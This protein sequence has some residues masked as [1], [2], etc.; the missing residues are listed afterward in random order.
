MANR[1]RHSL[2]SIMALLLAVTMVI[3][4]LPLSVLA[5]DPVTQGLWTVYNDTASGYATYGDMGFTYYSPTT[6]MTYGANGGKDYVRSNNT[7]GSASNGIVV[8]ES[9]SYCDF[10]PVSDGTLT[11]YVGNASTKTGYVSKTDANGTSTA[12]GSYVPGGSDNYDTDGFKVTQGKTWATL[13][14]EVEKGYTYY[15]NLSGSKMFCYGAEFVAYTNVTGTISDSFGLGNYDIKFTNKTTGEVKNAAVTGN[16]YS[17]ILKPGYEY[18]ASLSGANALGYAISNDTR[19]VNVAVGDTQTANLTIEKSVSYLLSGNITGATSSLPADT[20]LVFVP[21]DT[22]SH[23]SVTA[24]VD[25]TKAT[26]TAQ[27]VAN[28]TYTATLEGACDY[29]LASAVTVI[30]DSSSAITRDIQLI[31]LPTYQVNG[32]FIGLTQTRGVYE[33]LSVQ[34]V[35]VTFTNVEDGYSYTGTPSAGTY[36]V[37]LRNGSYEASI[38]SEDYSTSTHVT[39]EGGATS[40]DLLLKKITVEPLTYRDTLYVGSDKEFKSVQAA[41]DEATAM[42]RTSGQRVTI[43]IDPGVYREQVVV[44]TPDITLESNGGTRD[45]T[46][47]TW[48]YG[49]GYK[50]YSCVD[51]CY[52]PY[53]D[54]DKFEKGNVTSYWGAAVITNKEAEGFRAK[55]ITFEN[56]FN[57]YMTDEEIADGAEPNGLEAISVARK[58]TT[59]VDSRE[60]TERAA[61]YVNYADKTEFLDCSFIGSQD[62]LYTCNVAYDAYYKNCYIE[63][64][65]DFIY[66]NGDVIFDGCEINLCGYDGTASAGYLTA[67]SSSEKY[68]AEFGY[69]FRGCYISYNDERD[70]TA[71]YLGRTWGDSARVTFIDTQLENSDMILGAGWSAMSGVNPTDPSV[72]LREFNTTYNGVQIDT[73]GRVTGAV[74]ELDRSQY[75]VENVMIANGWTPAYYTPS[76]ATAAVLASAPTMTSNGDLNAPNP[77]ETITLGYTPESDWADNDVSTIA[78]YAVAEGYDDTSLDT[79]LESATLLGVES[80]VSTNKFQIP[81]ECAGKYIMAVVTPVTIEG[82]AG[83]PSYIIDREKPVSATWSD[84]DNEGSIAPGSGINIY[85][86]GDSTVKD[87]SAN[88]IYNG[89]KILESGSW[90]EFLQLFFNSDYVTVNNY[91]QGGRSTRSFIN[92]GKLDT[93]AGNIKAGDYLFIQFGHND[94]A[95]GASYYEERF[96]PLFTA[97]TATERP[98]PTIVPEESMKVATP[99]ALQSSYGDTYYSWDC[100]ATYKGYLQ[101][102]IDVALEKG[103]IPVI[104]SPVSR[105]YYNSDGTIKA[106]H[107]A[108]MTDYAPTASYVTSDDAYVTA[109]R[110]IYEANKDKGVLYLDAFNMTKELYQEAYK[111]GGEAYGTDIFATGDKTHSNKT[112]GVI[113]AG[114]IAKW[115]QDA[116]ISISQYVTQPTTAYGENPDG[117]Y[118]F[119][120]KNKEFTANNNSYV[121]NSYWTE[122]GQ[123]LFDSIGGTVTPTT[124]SVTLN[125]ATQEALDLYVTNAA[126]TFTDGAFSGRYTNAEGDDYDVTIYSSGIQ[127]YNNDIRYGTKA[128]PGKPIFSFTADAAAVYTITGAASTGS[129]TMGLYRDAA[130]TELVASASNTEPLVYK[131]TTADPEVLYYANVDAGNMYLME[132]TISHAVP[133][134]VNLNFSSE[135]ALAMYE[136]NAAD[137]FTGGKLTGEYINTMGQSFDVSVYQASIQYYNSTAHY[138]TKLSVKQPVISFT[139]DERA[140]YTINVRAGTGSGTINIY[141]DEACTNSIVNSS[142]PGSVVYKKT[143]T[144]PE[145][146]Y[147]A[148]SAVNNLYVSDIEIVKEE[149][150]TDVKVNFKGNVTGIEADDTN[151]V[152]T[153][154][155]ATETLTL[156]TEQYQNEGVEL[157]V[158]ETYVLSAKGDKGVYLGTDLV[159]DD[160]GEADLV[161]S[162]IVFDFPLNFI[163]YYEDYKAYLNAVGY[164]SADITDAY[165]G[166]TVHPNGIVMTD[167]YKNYGVKT[168]AY[169]ILSF[170]AKQTGVCTVSF[171]S[172]VSNSDKLILKVND[173]YVPDLKLVTQGGVTTLSTIVNK[174]DTVTLY[175]PTRSNLWFTDIDVTYSEASFNV[176]GSVISSDGSEVLVYGVIP[177]EYTANVNRVGFIFT[178]VITADLSQCV[179]NDS[180]TTVYNTVTFDGTDYT[181]SGNKLFG[182]IINELGDMTECYAYGVCET[183][184]GTFYSAPVRIS[185]K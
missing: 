44:N 155:S 159:P 64:Q 124:P 156:T 111:A 45:N 183:S 109:C 148:P 116:G 70:V 119:T 32:K 48:Y 135:D 175:T 145:T 100:G 158:G 122:Y 177:D 121:K 6:T 80:A 76:T 33:D 117:N 11:V 68:P 146:L 136:T 41:V 178:D 114:I 125:F 17:I 86:A 171:T 53:A 29:E 85:L 72:T 161:L 27:L 83:E 75:T 21:S 169:E 105:L 107:D 52:N 176:E 143:T 137:T 167:S 129:G 96:A 97:D 67:N 74:T 108:T 50:Y 162:R 43:K 102:Y 12:V 172:S 99:S 157:I 173:V 73:S 113:Q 81:M 5:A 123:S 19:L 34:P 163:E 62:T 88:G 2:R 82:L 71:S 103:A 18:S 165:S 101:K 16:S 154:K 134:S 180:S 152:I 130:C 138:G 55:D 126:E 13:E 160:S 20:K 77:G 15:V 66:G 174:G 63:G 104:V 98:Y 49:I 84:P 38:V 112:G 93:I 106:H 110:E 25:L 31:A 151:V 118:I 185:F 35:S 61:A 141:T 40:R 9:K 7:N 91:A 140:M 30:N 58:E 78:W 166:I 47:I 147:I 28:E 26:Y 95:N 65:T 51:S 92:E 164:G 10:T 23:E 79:I 59:N 4:M 179:V 170:E 87:Y 60:A 181:V 14:I 37:A 46:K 8:T 42:T 94:C 132:I 54:Y 1:T 153:L 115:I 149:L 3:G 89:G 56:S 24:A 57:K 142:V 90:G 144:A 139:A 69:I 39:V 131:K 133:K 150:P 22:T 182:S 168:N 36:S 128:T 120:I 127:Y 184:Q